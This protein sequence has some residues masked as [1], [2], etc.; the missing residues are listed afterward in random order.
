FSSGTETLLTTLGLVTS[1]TNTGL[2]NG[3]TYYYRVSALNGVGEGGQSGE[4]WATPAAIVTVPGA[5][6]LNSATAGNGQITL[7]WSAPTSTGGSTITGYRVYRS[8][9]RGTETLLTTLG[10]V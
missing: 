3:I 5:P 6:T 9:S 1:W 4:R 2:A 10:L 7:A 8:F